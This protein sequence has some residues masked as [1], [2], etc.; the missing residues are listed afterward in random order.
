[1][2][3]VQGA[4][5]PM[6]F[7]GAAPAGFPFARLAR[8]RLGVCLGL[9]WALLPTATALAQVRAPLERNLPPVITGQGGLLL[10]P[11]D[12]GAGT[13]ET[14]LGV[15]LRG[16]VLIGP[17][18]AVP[19]QPGRGI[20]I[21]A[22][23]ESPAALQQALTPFVGRPLTRKLVSD[24]QAAIATA[25]RRAGYPFVSVTLPPQ[26]VTQG[27]LVL[28]VVEFRMGEMKVQGASPESE[29]TLRTRVRAVPGERIAADAL[30]EDLDWLNRTP[31]RSVSGVFEPGDLPGSSTM[32][33][34]VTT[35]K[36]WQVFG[37]WSNTGTHA[38]GLD[39][40]FAGFGAALPILGDSFISYQVT[41]SG[42]FWSEPDH[43]GTGPTQP[44][45]YSQAGRFVMP[46]A[47]RQS[48]EI[49][50]NYVATRQQGQI[51]AF[52][53]T[54]T[55]FE[56]PV[57]YRTAISNLI[58]GAYLGDLI[59]GVTGKSVSRSSYFEEVSVGGA[60]AGLFELIAGWSV[61]RSD[62]MGRTGLDLRLLA[63]T[64]GIVGGNS[65]ESW[66]V[67]SGGRVT[68]VTY[69]YGV[70]DL[71]RV[72][73]LPENF[74]WVSQF[75]GTLA[76]QALPDTEQI[77]LGGLYATRGYT[78]DDGS[79]DTGFVWRNELRSPV[80]SPLSLFGVSGLRDEMSP[81]A[82]LD[83]GWGHNYGW[84]GLLGP[85]PAYDVQMAGVGLGFDYR[86]AA[87]LTAS[88]A[89]GCALTDA[90]YTETGDLSL[91]GRISVTF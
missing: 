23:G 20:T 87:S 58:P 66:T 3:V 11:Q 52:S 31:Y 68:D 57:L 74:T 10:G 15:E 67:F 64:G 16:I 88:F 30:E 50:P 42:N 18:Q 13:D 8:L 19:V 29:A 82:F 55:T 36:P 26:E 84:Q 40:Y 91:Q 45:Y 4:V 53:F 83:V 81:Y 71:N 79:A 17:K 24:M 73:R 77:S 49:V 7:R 47:A 37:G 46:F 9:L 62:D 90:I 21:G 51:S 1:M 41:G 44:S 33:L 22:I 65:R 43:V 75:N 48:I 85:V 14:P 35:Q 6:Q 80:I 39:R 60:N 59:L 72:T 12:L 32:T 2:A 76:G 89:L 70:L 27:A 54:N 38:T 63:N 5:N 25:Y 28:R 78:L 86:L 61:A 56:L 34:E 69:A